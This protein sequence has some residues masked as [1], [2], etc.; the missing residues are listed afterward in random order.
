L[1]LQFFNKSFF[2]SNAFIIIVV[3]RKESGLESSG[4]SKVLR[5]ANKEGYTSPF[6]FGDNK[7]SQEDHL[8]VWQMQ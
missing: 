8:V 3:K 7:R 2:W 5:G 6:E 1:I 4:K